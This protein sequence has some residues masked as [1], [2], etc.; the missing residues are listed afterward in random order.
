MLRSDEIEFE[1]EGFSRAQRRVQF[2]RRG[3]LNDLH[4]DIQ[5]V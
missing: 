1:V 3:F 4:L 5:E 2:N